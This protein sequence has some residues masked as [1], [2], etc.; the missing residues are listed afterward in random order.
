LERYHVLDIFEEGAPTLLLKSISSALGEQLLPSIDG[1]A[2]LNQALKVQMTLPDSDPLQSLSN[3]AQA[4]LEEIR[5]DDRSEAKGISFMLISATQGSYVPYLWDN[6][7]HGQLKVAI[8]PITRKMQ[9]VDELVKA[10][11]L[12]HIHSG[13]SL[14]QWALNPRFYPDAQTH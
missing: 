2:H 5:K 3:T 9:G 10:G 4:M 11:I 1:E 6:H 7:T 12:D 14:H 13:K 8:S